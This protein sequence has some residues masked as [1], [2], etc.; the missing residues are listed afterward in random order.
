MSLKA[1]YYVKK[2]RVAPNGDPIT[3]GEKC[4]L[5]YLADAHNEERYAGVSSKEERRRIKASEAEVERNAAW[6]SIGSIA[7]D[8]DISERRVREI[9]AEC[10]RKGIIWRD[11]RLRD[12][13][14][15]T[16][17]FWR[18]NAIDGDPSG[19]ALVAEH[20]RKIRGEL[21][22]KK[23]NETKASAVA[24]TAETFAQNSGGLG[25]ESSQGTDANIRMRG[26]E[27]SQ[28]EGAEV[29]THGCESSQGEDAEVRSQRVRELASL[30]LP[31]ETP[32]DT[33][34]TL[35]LTSDG[36]PPEPSTAAA[37]DIGDQDQTQEPEGR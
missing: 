19:A 25:C 5:W 29:R 23:A 18:F 11:E 7:K 24:E 14:C 13:G 26:C 36:E 8:N 4:L 10:I 17:N 33:P 3:L 16:S 21:A 12:T 9:L 31:V 27:S 20:K 34:L 15:N 28:G 1:M 22:A 2:L 32:A 6:V 37:V 30:E 35:Q